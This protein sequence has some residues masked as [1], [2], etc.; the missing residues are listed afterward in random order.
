MMH[1]LAKRLG[2]LFLLGMTT[3]AHAEPLQPGQTYGGGTELD[4]VSLGLSFTVPD[5][6]TALLPPGSSI[7]VMTPDDQ[8]YVL[9][10]AN[11]ATLDEARSALSE[12]L[13]LGNGVVLTPSATPLQA[14]QDLRVSYT[15]SGLSLAYEGDGRSRAISNEMV[16]SVVALAATGALDPARQVASQFLDSVRVSSK[17]AAANNNTND[18]DWQS[19]LLGRHLVQYFGNSSYNETQHIYLCA[20][21][22]FRKTVGSGGHTSYGD[23]WSSRTTGERGQGSV[24]CHCVR[25]SRLL[26]P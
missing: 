14:G 13:A 15:V 7:L 3:A 2:L 19:Y 5:G 12:P 22:H 1:A 23:G 8:S 20:D 25:K 24:A 21:G 16:V 18:D 6:W 10:A 4:I 26:D 9:A 17:P 11:H